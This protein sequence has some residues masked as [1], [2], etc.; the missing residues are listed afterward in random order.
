MR[1]DAWKRGRGTAFTGLRSRAVRTDV[2]RA[3]RGKAWRAVK[4][5]GENGC[6]RHMKYMRGEGRYEQNI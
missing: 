5:A 6:W 3:V 4:K 2:C 1:E